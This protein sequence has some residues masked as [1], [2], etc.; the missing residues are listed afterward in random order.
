LVAG[1]LALTL[2][3][4]ALGGAVVAIR[5]RPEP[6][7]ENAVDRMVVQWQDAVDHDPDNAEMYTGLG[8][9][10]QAADRDAEARAAFE[11]AVT[12]DD[13][14]WLAKFQLGLLVED[15]DP[16]RAADLIASAA[17]LAPEQERVAPL[18]AFGDLLL[19]Q[20]D[21]E[22]ARD[23]YRRSLVYDPFLFDSHFGLGAAYE[24]LGNE[25]AA[26]QAYEEAARFDPN[27]V[28]VAE[29]IDRLG[30]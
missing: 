16:D 25:K 9:A 6:L 5:L 23:A 28:E 14:A 29:A 15:T 24:E 12:L 8:L 11:R 30:G 27:N 2:V 13:A 3:V 1:V 18:I 26:L 4:L 19:S 17:K 20:G 7:P 21:A 10:L 22:G